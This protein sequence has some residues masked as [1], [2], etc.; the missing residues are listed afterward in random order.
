ME[1]IIKTNNYLQADEFIRKIVSENRMGAIIGEKGTGKTFVRR[2]ILGSF[3][4]RKG[5]YLIID[6]VPMRDDDRCI[7]QIM[8]AMIDDI[9]SGER[10]RRDVEA[11]R[12][13]LRRV[14]GD[15]NR[16]V[17]LV[18]DEAQDLHKST[19]RGIKK[20][21]ELGFGMRD[22]L[23]A[24]ILFG[25]PSLKDKISDDELR[26][27]FRRI[28]FKDLT[29]KE[30][31][32]FIGNADNFTQEA[33][34]AFLSQTR[35]TPLAIE[36]AYLELEE[37]REKLDAKKIEAKIVRDFFSMGLVEAIRAMDKSERQLVKDIKLVTGHEVS[38]TAINQFKNNKYPG[39]L[40]KLNR[41]LNEYIE[42]GQNKK[43]FTQ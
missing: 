12:K 9:S 11:R 28:I 4:E 34:A 15:T 10:I 21:H 24:V 42:A 1:N 29:E 43:A 19:L 32:L 7:A 14:L 40:S 33:L 23:F 38:A 39:N 17:I 20:L 41:I 16:K 25:H 8:S 3:E 26:P 30:K 18:M 22:S 36:S 6:V 31:K 37:I 2:K 27:R 13:Q 35:S 5:E